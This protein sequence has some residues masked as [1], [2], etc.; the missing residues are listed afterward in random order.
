MCL[1][2]VLVISIYTECGFSYGTKRSKHVNLP[3]QMIT[4]FKIPKMR[5]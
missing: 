3:C 1:I 5:T 2:R 4:M